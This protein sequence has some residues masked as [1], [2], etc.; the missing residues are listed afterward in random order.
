MY[1]VITFY[2][3]K[4]MRA[5]GDLSSI[6][7]QLKRLMADNLVKGTII[8]ADEGFNST[9]CGPQ[10]GIGAFVEGANL[11][12]QTQL[13]YKSSFHSEVPFRKIDV[14][15][16]PEIVTL[17]KPVDISKG[18]GTHV[19]PEEWN[20]LLED[21]EVVVLDTRNDY[22]FKSGTFRGAV[23]PET[24]KFSELP[25]FVEA[26]FDPERHTKIAMFCTGGIRCEKFAPYMKE[27]GFSEVYQ[28]EGGIL[29][30]LEDVPAE[31][32]RWEG[33]CFIFDDRRSLDHSLKK[34]NS[35]DYSQIPKTKTA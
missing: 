18:E 21:P 2:E 8:L 20:K 35:P 34:G 15:I 32:S 9:V 3:F 30:Y 23:N 6:K 7:E 28:L 14:K 11:I 31:E 12:L 4:D 22:E 10:E 1:Q 16:K 26:N 17:K 27:L 33:E 29:K 25:E 24:E 5:V 19:K 13:V